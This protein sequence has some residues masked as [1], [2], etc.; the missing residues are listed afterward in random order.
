[1]ITS[2]NA[3]VLILGR[4]EAGCDLAHLLTS[5]GF[6]SRWVQTPEELRYVARSISPDVILI[7]VLSGGFNFEHCRSL[8]SDPLTESISIL[9]LA[10]AAARGDRLNATQ[11]GVDDFIVQPFDPDEVVIR[12]RN[13]VTRTRQACALKLAAARLQQLEEART[14]LTRLVV[15]DMKT[16]LTG[17]A[18]LLEVAGG[19]TSKH[20]KVDASRFVNEALGATETLEELIEFLMSVRKMMAGEEVPDKQP[21]D[22]LQLARY[23]SEALSESAQAM[24]ITLGVEGEDAT[25]LCDK[26]QMTRVI[27]HMIRL[28]IKA[29]PIGN[30]VMIRIE[31]IEGRIKLL[32]VCAGGPQDTAIDADGLGLTYCRLVTAAHGGDFGVPFMDGESAYMCVTLPEAVGIKQA[33]VPAEVP[34]PIEMERSRRYLGAFA[35]HG[36]DAK[37]RSLISLGTRQQFAVAVALMSVIPLLAFAYVL[38]NAIVTRSLDGETLFLLLPSI[39]GM[40]ALGAM[41]LVRHT[42][43]VNRLRRYLE[44]MSRG[45]EPLVAADQSSEDFV[46]IQRSIG[47]VIKQ[48]SEQVREIE[49]HSKALVQAEQQRVMVETVGAACHHLGQPATIIRGYLELM[50]RSE[51]SPEMR[52]M[53]QE[54]QAATE[55][56]ATVLHRLKKVG[57]YETE[58]YLTAK[59]ERA[60]RADERILKI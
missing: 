49:A 13:V 10:T 26:P 55:D 57:Q 15:R 20:F 25:V 33:A 56:V 29:K 4:D 59:E 27:R 1:M 3:L 24:G 38:G 39:V 9:V 19:A 35:L 32:V 45:G 48:G 60:G 44:E 40:M 6:K 22:I 41:L 11:C 17:L 53:I 7:N 2:E 36:M 8:K 34:V 58:P 46:A 14:E 18:D 31:R 16:P 51:V 30:Q 12:L 47:A 23:I 43:E 42:L 54:C 21:C 52:A 28:A 37:K 5:A 50:K